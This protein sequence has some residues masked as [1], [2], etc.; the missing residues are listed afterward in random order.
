MHQNG[1]VLYEPCKHVGRMLQEV[2]L[3]LLPAGDSSVFLGENRIN[4][5]LNWCRLIKT[6]GLSLWRK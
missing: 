1:W 2:A 4:A 6:A 3:L 5:Q